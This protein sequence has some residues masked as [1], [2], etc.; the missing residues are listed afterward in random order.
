[1]RLTADNLKIRRGNRLVI[2]ELS[3][4][5][6]SGEALLLTGPNGAGKTTLLRA[7]AGFLPLESG[8]IALD[9]G[10]LE[11]EIG[12]QAHYVGHANGIKSSLT[13]GENLE[14]WGAY[15]DAA[16]SRAARRDR[17]L[18]ALERLKLASLEDIPAAYLSAG[19]KRR[20][21]LGR[22]LVADRPLWLLDEPTVSLDAAS[23]ALLAGIVKEHLAGGG[24]VLAATH[25]PLGLSDARELRLGQMEAAR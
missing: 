16:A 18:D 10:D 7:I 4:A 23:V 24:L 9:G 22:L 6:V 2:D 14:F 13:A 1:M 11:H 3:F 19:Q 5:A 8:N 12:E 17:V 20:L 15:L 25:I 21:G